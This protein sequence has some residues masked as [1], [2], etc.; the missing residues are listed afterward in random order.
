MDWSEIAKWVAGIVALVFG[1]GLAFKFVSS[2]NTSVRMT[3]QKNNK[4]G[5]DIIGGDS[6][7]KTGK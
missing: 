5:G 3:S 7:K 6:A 1:G 4:A 2:R